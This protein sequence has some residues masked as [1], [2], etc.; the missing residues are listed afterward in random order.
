MEPKERDKRKS[1]ISSKF[2]FIYIHFIIFFN[3][4][5]LCNLSEDMQQPCLTITNVGMYGI[6]PVIYLL[7]RRSHSWL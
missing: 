1:N 5:V 6:Y 3:H 2:H 7:F 4:P